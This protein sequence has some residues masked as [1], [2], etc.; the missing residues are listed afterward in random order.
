MHKNR[1]RGMTMVEVVVAFT[2]LA[3]IMGILYS[4]IRLASNLMRETTD[5]DRDNEK[6]GYAVTDYFRE[7]SNYVLGTSDP[8]TISFREVRDDGM[9]GDDFDI[10][11]YR[12][13]LSFQMISGAYQVTAADTGQKVRKL[14]LFSTGNP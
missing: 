4:C 10:Q 6:F 8:I 5:V 14:Y 9:P 11:V 1:D 12:A 2:V 13:N 3:L 7:G